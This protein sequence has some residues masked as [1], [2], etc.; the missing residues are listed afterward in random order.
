MGPTVKV[1]SGR[2]LATLPGIRK[3][4][5]RG[6]HERR[7][8]PPVGNRAVGVG[9]RARYGSALLRA[10]S[11]GVSQSCYQLCLCTLITHDGPLALF[12]LSPLN[13]V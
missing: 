6:A 7:F 10:P 3:F 11:D 5:S 4:A 13:P 2:R 1:P 9:G 12:P 8:L